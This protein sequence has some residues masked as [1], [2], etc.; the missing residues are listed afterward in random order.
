MIKGVHH[1]AISCKD[2]DQSIAF[3]RD[4]FGM[5]VIYDGPFG[6]EIADITQLANPKGRVVFMRTG[7][8]HL[9]LFD[10][11]SPNPREHH[12][13]VNDYGITH[14]CLEVSDIDVE[15]E[16]LSAAGV[17]FTC[18]PRDLGPLSATYAHDPD[19]NIVELLELAGGDGSPLSI[20]HR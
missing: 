1:V 19:G 15:Y 10:F 20:N 17:S 9:E 3:Y 8:A 16:R 6:D 18:A 4:L 5:T 7:N 13:A 11:A 2:L 12:T 14:F